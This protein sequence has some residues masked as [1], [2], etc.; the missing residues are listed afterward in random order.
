MDFSED[1][2]LLSLFRLYM[3]LLHP[4]FQLKYRMDPHIP[5]FYRFLVLFSRINISFALAFF[6]LKDL[7]NPEQ[8]PSSIGP[9]LTFIFV[10]SLLFTPLPVMIYT[11]FKSQYY[12]LKAKS[13]PNKGGSGQ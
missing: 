8:S 5:R 13:D 4:I 7:P 12:L 3:M 6:L 2:N 9:L 11:P 10:A 1:Y